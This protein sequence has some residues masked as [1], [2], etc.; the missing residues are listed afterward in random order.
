MLCCLGGLTAA[1]QTPPGSAAPD[2][3]AATLEEGRRLYFEGDYAGARAA[4]APL[5]EAGNARAL[6]NMA[7]LYRRG[8]GVDRDRARARE[9]LE[10]SAEQGFAEAQYLLADLLMRNRDADEAD[11]QQAA[12]WWLSA[13]RQ[14]HALSQYRL[15]LLYWNGE[16]VA[17]DLV[18]GHA[19]MRLASANDLE[20]AGKALETMQQYLS[21]EQQE[22]S[23]GLAEEL[24]REQPA[25]LARAQ[26]PAAPETDPVAAET[27]PDPE[28]DP[29]TEETGTASAPPAQ[30]SRQQETARPEVQD[31]SQGWR[32]QIAALKDRAT[33]EALWQRLAR[34]A[35]DLVGDIEHRVQEADLGE[36]GIFYRLRIGPFASRDAAVRRCRSL[37]S[38]GFGCFPIAPDS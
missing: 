18:R 26:L 10:R 22:A 36:R 31:F 37:D 8:L 38:A 19:W 15:G 16:A 2:E 5:A 3:A 7:T 12:R 9:M 25:E 29:E 1:A 33:A 13:A 6:Y 27:P 17:R 4:W 24:R 20:D 28:P 35:P 21:V 34:E 32:L 11:K 14:G 30:E 23:A